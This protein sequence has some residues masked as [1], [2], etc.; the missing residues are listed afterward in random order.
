MAKKDYE[1]VTVRLPVG[2]KMKIQEIT[3]ESYNCYI[4]RL[5]SE[6]FSKHDFEIKKKVERKQKFLDFFRFW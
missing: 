1:P 6:D 3:D 5:V 2:S 4:N